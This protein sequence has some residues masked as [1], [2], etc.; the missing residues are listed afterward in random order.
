MN[1]P[2]KGEFRL[3]QE[4]GNKLEIN[5]VDIYGEYGLL[6]HNGID[7]GLPNGTPIHAPHSGK[8]LERA[9][10]SGGYGEY[11]K[12][13][14][15]AQGSI[16]AHLQRKFV[17]SVGQEVG[18]GEHIGYSN[19]TGNSTG[20]HLHWG[21]YTLPRDRSNG[22]SGT[23][24]QLPII[25]GGSMPEEGCLLYRTE[26][27][28]KTFADLVDKSTKYSNFLSAGYPSVADVKLELSER[29][30]SIEHYKKLAKAEADRA[31][32]AL[33]DFNDLRAMAATALGTTQEVAQIRIAFDKVKE[34]LEELDSL[35]QNYPVIQAELEKSQEE[36]TALKE[37]LK[38][39]FTGI[40][41][42]MPIEV[43]AKIQREIITWVGIR[44]ADLAKDMKS[45]LKRS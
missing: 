20:P 21:Y 26:K 42:D 14:N 25:Q 40:T 4:W 19:N 18:E 45:R 13:Q 31:K 30:K 41:P 27:D 16:L 12:I 5:G 11:I 36:V 3:T 32:D 8:I 29:N 9:Y 22:Y 1:K 24:N 37:M 44:L 6:G 10:D 23:I 35:R 2:F 15:E 33:D 43:V 34:E 38:I 39:S 7:W 28:K 17:V